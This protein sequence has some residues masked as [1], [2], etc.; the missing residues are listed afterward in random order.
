MIPSFG[1]SSNAEIN[2]DYESGQVTAYNFGSSVNVT[3][4]SSGGSFKAGTT[5]VDSSPWVTSATVT[6]TSGGTFVIK[7]KNHSSASFGQ[8]TTTSVTGTDP[9]ASAS[10]TYT[11]LT[12]GSVPQNIQFDIPAGPT[13]VA[14]N[15]NGYVSPLITVTGAIPNT[16]ISVSAGGGGT[17]LANGDSN[18]WPPGGG[19][20]APGPAGL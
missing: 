1:S 6:T 18:Y 14:L 2:S 20:A 19:G 5:S 8:S 11:V 16:P 13:N 12:K 4:S 7:A 9:T 3:I 15:G 17:V 10:S